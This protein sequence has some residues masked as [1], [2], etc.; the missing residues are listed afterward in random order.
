MFEV[1]RKDDT[2]FLKPIE[3][4]DVR[5]DRG[6]VYFCIYSEIQDKYVY[7]SANFFRPAKGKEI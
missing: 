1:Y 5:V 4:V 6:N 3:V 7:E 2:N